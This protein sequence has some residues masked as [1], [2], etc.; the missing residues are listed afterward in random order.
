MFVFFNNPVYS[1][2]GISIRRDENYKY[3]GILFYQPPG[4][5]GVLSIGVQNR[6]TSWKL[7]GDGVFKKFLPLLITNNPAIIRI[8]TSEEKPVFG[9][10]LSVFR[11]RV[12]L[13]L[14]RTRQD[15]GTGSKNSNGSKKTNGPIKRL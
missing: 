6:K 2:S 5:I 8:S 7:L 10:R 3:L 15:K 4:R 9:I 11:T 14:G 12:R 13:S 1:G